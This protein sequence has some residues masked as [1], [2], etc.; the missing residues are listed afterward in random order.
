MLNNFVAPMIDH[1]HRV[2]SGGNN[3]VTASDLPSL[4]ITISQADQHHPG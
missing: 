3:A 2:G 4:P 1:Q